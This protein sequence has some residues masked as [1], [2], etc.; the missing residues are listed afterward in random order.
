[1]ALGTDFVGPIYIGTRPQ[2]SPTTPGVNDFEP[3]QC[4]ARVTLAANAALPVTTVVYVPV[5][6]TIQDITIDTVTAWN[7]TTAPFTVGISA[8]D[9]TYAGPVAQATAGRARP[10]FTGPQLN[11]MGNV[12]WPAALYV[13]VAPTG[14]NTTG[15]SF[16]TVEFTPVS[17]NAGST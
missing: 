4:A 14:G 3:V 15:L 12:V 7:G 2:T 8:G 9:S 13:T 16:I 1:M 5:G 6:S 17:T 11:A 10:T